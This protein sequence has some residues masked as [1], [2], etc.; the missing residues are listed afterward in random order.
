MEGDRSDYVTKLQVSELMRELDKKIN[1]TLKEAN[2]LSICE[3]GKQLLKSDK[4]AMTLAS[5]LDKSLSIIN[6]SIELIDSQVE[7]QKKEIADI[8]AELWKY[9]GIGIGA[10]TGVSLFITIMLFMFGKGAV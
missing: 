6:K 7:L 10:S 5:A 4:D 9:I 1:E 2:T 8:R 3:N